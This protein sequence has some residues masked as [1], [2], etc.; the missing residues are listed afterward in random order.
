[1]AAR[2][3]QLIPGPGLFKNNAA[4][5]RRGSSGA[6]LEIHSEAELASYHAR[7]AGMAPADMLAWLHSPHPRALTAI[8]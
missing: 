7:V 8:L 3:D 1:M 5:F 4:F 2:A 6:G